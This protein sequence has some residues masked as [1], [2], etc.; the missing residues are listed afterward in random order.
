[1]FERRVVLKYGVAGLT[2]ML[3]RAGLAQTP[4]S[5][6]ARPATGDTKPAPEQARARFD[7]AQLV[8]IARGLSK[9]AY[10]APS[11]DLPDVFAGLNYEQYVGIRN[12][13]GTAIWANEN[14]GYAIEPLHRGFVYSTPVE[15]NVIE[16]G[17]ARRLT[18]S[19]NDFSFGGVKPPA[20]TKDIGFSGFR[21]L[22][23]SE[24]QP[25]ADV[26]IFQ[27]A[28][29]FRAIAN[30][31]LYGP[32]ARALSIR[33]ADPKGEEF[34]LF[35]AVWIEK[36][37]LATPLAIYALLD[38]ES[39]TGAYRFTLRAGDA[40][41]IDTECTL[42]PRATLEHIGL[43]AMTATH[44]A[45]P[46]DRRRNDDVRPGIY[47]VSGLEMLN[48][49]DEWIWR[50]VSNRE[51]LQISAFVDENPKG[52]GFVQRDREFGRFLDD[53]NHWERRPTLWI[54]PIG[55]WGAG[56]VA[57]VEIPSDSEV[58]QNIIA[59]WRPRAPLAA[60]SETMFAYRQFWCWS[61]PDKPSGA[62]VTLS[63]GGRPPGASASTRRRRFL[64][65]FTGDVIG[66]QQRSPEITPMIAASPGSVSSV[67][68]FVNR[69]RKTFRVLFDIDPGSDASSELRLQ[70]EVQ[71]KPISETWLYRWT[72]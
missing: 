35:R 17:I 37:S 61:P 67:R 70:L 26:A 24:G 55:D 62:L 31:Q 68:T 7:L 48:G 71:G 16:D 59:Y 21:V 10:R 15:L 56:S 49:R 6:P 4:A 5:E 9:R 38:S 64:V 72:P 39:V 58:N 32:T 65:D 46:L 60:G 69:D 53:D 8:E 52:F 30:G 40:T 22:R 51:I 45:G 41:I 19:P 47:D 29:F 2:G 33:T 66:D 54:E 34:P 44:V 12:Q 14:L 18:Y 57:L 63:R 42:F 1:M 20:E 27:G 13:P 36:P 3:T 25:A 23:T 43:G 28:S 50:P 11:A